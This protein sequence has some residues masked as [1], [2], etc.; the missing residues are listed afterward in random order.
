M[1]FSIDMGVL[2]YLHPKI[3]D[4]GW[5]KNEAD[6]NLHGTSGFMNWEPSKKTK[7]AFWGVGCTLDWVQRNRNRKKGI[8]DDDDDDSDEKWDDGY[9]LDIDEE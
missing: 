1:G 4:A 3:K 6:M 7:R 2:G 8:K 5:E 9:P